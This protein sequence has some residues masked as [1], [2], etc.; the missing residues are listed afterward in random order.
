[1]RFTYTMFTADALA[2]TNKEVDQTDY[3]M[4][5]EEAIANLNELGT[6]GWRVVGQSILPGP[7]PRILSLS[8]KKYPD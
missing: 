7:G 1:M 5:K 6:R 8:S 3:R 4:Q 2:L